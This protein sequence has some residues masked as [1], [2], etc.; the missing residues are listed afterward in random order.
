MKTSAT[1]PEPAI[2]GTAPVETER[3]LARLI[4]EVTRTGVTLRA[5]RS[6]LACVPKA[7]KTP[8][9]ELVEAISLLLAAETGPAHNRGEEFSFPVDQLPDPS[10]T[11]RTHSLEAA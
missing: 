2:M 4:E 9:V 11:A 8:P 5:M 7:P 6:L 1:T 10:S 3:E